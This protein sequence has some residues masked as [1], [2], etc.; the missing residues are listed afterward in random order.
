MRKL[1]LG[2]ETVRVL[3]LDRVTGGFMWAGNLKL[4][5]NAMNQ[6]SKGVSCGG[7]C[8]SNGKTR[9]CASQLGNCEGQ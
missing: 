5:E 1:R 8:V 9:D 3:E 6:Y 4:G 7:L 2:I